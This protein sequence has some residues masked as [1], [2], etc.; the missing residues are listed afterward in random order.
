MRK[1]DQRS[2]CNHI[3]DRLGLLSLAQGSGIEVASLEILY[4]QVRLPYPEIPKNQGEN[5][6]SF[7]QEQFEPKENR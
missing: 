2:K 3:P 5:L 1:Q 7:R 6:N 4:Q